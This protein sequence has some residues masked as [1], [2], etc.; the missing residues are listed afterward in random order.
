[1]NICYILANC[2]FS[3]VVWGDF[4]LCPHRPPFISRATRITHPSEK[5]PPSHTDSQ[6]ATQPGATT[7]TGLHLPDSME[8]KV[9][10]RH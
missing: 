2:S 7:N 10:G 5:L 4:G 8:I 3:R 1:M 9:R 6:N